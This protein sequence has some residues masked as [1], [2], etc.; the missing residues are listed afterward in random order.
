M[1]E[2]IINNIENTAE[3]ERLYRSNSIEFSKSFKEAYDS[4]KNLPIADF[5]VTRLKFDLI[6]EPEFE[7]TEIKE[8]PEN[9]PSKRFKFIYTIIASLIAGTLV[10]MPDILQTPD[11]NYIHNNIAFFLFPLLTIYYIIK[12]K[13]TVKSFIT[14][15]VITVVS[16]IFIN[17]LPGSSKSDTRVLSEIHLTL[18]MWIL[19]GI[20]FAGMD[21]RSSEKR[22]LYLKRNG[23]VIILTSVILCGGM[24][25]TG[26]TLGLFSV[27]KVNIGDFYFKYIAIYGL[28]AAPIVAN[29]MI[30][31]T[32]A[33]I[34][35]V[36]P[37]IS[38]IFTPLILIAMTCFLAA[39]TFFAK[40]PFNSRDEL[41]VF[42]VL[43]IV[44]LSIIV[45]SFSGQTA[46]VKSYYNKIIILLSFEAII[47]NSVAI[48]AIIYRLFLFGVSP[49]RIAVLGANIL[50]FVNLIIITIK[51]FMY[52]RNKTGIEALNKSIIV[53]MPYYAA[54]A[55]FMSFIFP[56]IFWFK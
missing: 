14:F 38:K 48:S 27:I 18:F 9:T 42:N 20:A 34:N 11:K 49:N 24:L 21:F 33:I 52:I 19:L 50:M 30:E 45:F 54:W 15:G 55:V 40:D 25:L 46:G 13:L 53:M 4:I 47:I 43:L 32:P 16:V 7:Q 41:I 17:L 2:Q 10:K 28:L 12:N 6:T 22:L 31:S 5:W 56:F 1:K 39:L 23:D 44:N 36:A 51:L 35:K 37:F 29:Y 3:L 26:L 8:I